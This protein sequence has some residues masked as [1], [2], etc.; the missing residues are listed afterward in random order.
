MNKNTKINYASAI[1]KELTEMSVP[2]N[3]RDLDE[4]T[5]LFAIPTRTKNTAGIE[6]MLIVDED[7]DS[8]LR[9][10]LVGDVAEDQHAEMVETLNRL[11]T[12]YRYIRL[13]LDEDG[14]VFAGYDFVLPREDAESAVQYALSMLKNF[15][16]LCDRCFPDIMRTIWDEKKP[17]KAQAAMG[18]VQMD[19]FNKKGGEN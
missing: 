4:T 6:V 11:N 19:L 8:G 9:C 5:K 3:T 13:N 2:H 16:G 12:M 18:H 10:R 1:E 17:S 14:D 7:G 15:V